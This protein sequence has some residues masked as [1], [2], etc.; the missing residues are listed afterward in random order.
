MRRLPIIITSFVAFAALAVVTHAGDSPLPAAEAAGDE[1]A[2]GITVHGNASLTVVPD[3]AQLWFGVE[4]RDAAAS[5]ALAANAREMRK[6]IDALRAAG[7]TDIQTQNVSLSPRYVEGS[8]GV[9][10]RVGVNGYT[11]HN[12]VTATVKELARAGALIDAAVAAGADHVSGPVLSSADTSALYRKALEAAVADARA[13]AEALA[14][15]AELTLGRIT[16]VVEGG[17]TPSPLAMT[18]ARAADEAA[19]T[20]IEP[21]EQ[22]VTAT[23]TVTFAAS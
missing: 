4:S 19:S 21:G 16:A 18:T 13:N 14:D 9:E 1:P 22:Q 8:T 15:A 20:P 5:A 2:K 23:V 10:G 6:L 7:A 12:S 3:R 17:E 11:A